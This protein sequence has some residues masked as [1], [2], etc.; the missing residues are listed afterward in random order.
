MHNKVSVTFLHGCNSARACYFTINLY[1]FFV[2]KCFQKETDPI[3][4][5]S[6]YIEPS[7]IKRLQEG[8]FLKIKRGVSHEIQFNYLD[9]NNYFL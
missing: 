7:I 6:V 2:G 3:L 9:K 1:T 4:S 8:E 5:V